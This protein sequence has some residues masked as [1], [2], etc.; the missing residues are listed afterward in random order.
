[1]TNRQAVLLAVA[2]MAAFLLPCVVAGLLL[3]GWLAWR[4]GPVP[5]AG[6]ATPTPSAFYT[7]C[8]D[9]DALEQRAAAAGGFGLGATTSSGSSSSSGPG[10][11]QANVR[12]ER[13]VE[14]RPADL[15]KVLAALKAE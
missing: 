5:V 13:A 2:I 9:L 15:G 3:F 10:R 1:M 14:C 8:Q 11:M 7:A 4:A 12:Q 6:G